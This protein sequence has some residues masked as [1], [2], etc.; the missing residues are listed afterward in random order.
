M[1]LLGWTVIALL[2]GSVQDPVA[3]DS[4]L[5]AFETTKGKV[6][7]K[8]HRSWSPLGVDRLYRLA[9]MG[10]YRDAVIYRVGGTKSYPGG[11]VVQFGLTNDSSINRQWSK[12]GIQDEP[13]RVRHRRGTVMFARDSANTRTVELAID[14]T[15]NSGLDTVHY[16]GV[17]GFPTIAEVVDGMAALDSLNRRHGNAPIENM[18]SIMVGGRRYLDRKFPGLDRVLT[19]AVVTEW[20]KGSGA[21]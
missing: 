19:V 5:V 17:V 12:R 2:T 20:R 14:L 4:F 18:D 11:F 1:I 3:P 13:V 21:R 8:A 9:K 6:V 10:F 15:P 16:Q 7:M